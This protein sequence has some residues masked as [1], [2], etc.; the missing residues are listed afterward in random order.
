MKRRAFLRSLG[1]AVGTGFG[2]SVLGAGWLGGRA[3]AQGAPA[4]GAWPD[5]AK[6]AELPAELRPDNV[7]EVFCMGG[8]SPWESLYCVDDPAYGQHADPAK[9][10]QWFTFLEGPDN[11]PDWYAT[12]V[13]GGDPLVQPWHEDLLGTTVNM[14]PFAAPL[15][16]RAD[17]L[18]RMRLHVV[19]HD[20]VP[21]DVA[22][23]MAFT[24]TRLGNPRMFGVGTAVQRHYA[25]L[26][27]L[28]LPA[29]YVIADSFGGFASSI[30]QHPS[31][32]RPPVLRVAA[33]AGF[34]ERF[35]S[36]QAKD[37]RTALLDHYSSHFRTRLTS[38]GSGAVARTPVLDDYLFALSMRSEVPFFADLLGSESVTPAPI[39]VCDLGSETDYSGAQYR[40]AAELLNLPGNPTRHVTLIER[41]YDPLGANPDAFDT[42]WDHVKLSA[43][44][45]PYFWQNLINTINAPGETDPNKLDLDRTLIVINTEFGRSP[46]RQDVTGRNHWPYGY[47]TA[48]FGG[49][50]GGA[51]KGIVGAIDSKGIAV[52]PLRPAETR[53]ATLA[54]LG[55]YPFS[56]D[57][58]SASDVSGSASELDAALKLKEIVLGVSS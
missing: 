47:V 15:R 29:A 58:F 30:G 55:V 39:A 51:Q 34:G 16:G 52:E 20:L 50:V 54:A 33:G 42:H 32:A 18:A 45:Y 7:L 24:G 8:L 3:R 28:D 10:E 38:S 37:A 46:G 41:A 5:F 6:A 17:I 53:A 31:A 57:A 22:R 43:R 13:G 36:L 21:H 25:S 48:M 26:G 1:A 11:V 9:R 2:A 35:L 12:C 56:S 19:A 27:P 23:A 14:G 44:K 49:P 4:W 40:L